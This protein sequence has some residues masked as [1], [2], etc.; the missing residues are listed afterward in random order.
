[1]KNSSFFVRGSRLLLVLALPQ[2]LKYFQRVPVQKESLSG[3]YNNSSAYLT[4]MIEC[5]H[6]S[7]KV[8]LPQN[9]SDT[10]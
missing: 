8:T 5:Y 2:F 4:Q 9:S 6:L 10:F 1:M 3:K 7:Y